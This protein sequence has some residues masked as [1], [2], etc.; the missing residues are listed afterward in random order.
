MAVEA[1]LEVLA[2]YFQIYLADPLVEDDWSD[3]WKAPSA[4]ADR[5][6][7]CPRIL[8]FATEHNATLPLRVF[9]HDAAPELSSQLARADHAI[10]AFW[11]P[12]IDD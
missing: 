10:R 6:I 8:G 1:D 2:D 5:V 11:P 4:L 12:R 3:A 9:S 7:V